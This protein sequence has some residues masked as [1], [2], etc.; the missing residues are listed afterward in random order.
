MAAQIV[1]GQLN[2]SPSFSQSGVLGAL[3]AFVTTQQLPSF[4]S[5]Q[6]VNGTGVAY[7]VDQLY[8]AQL[9]FT[10]STA[11]TFHFETATLTDPFGNTLAM[12]RIRELIVLNTSPT[13]GWDLSVAQAASN[14]IA[15]LPVVANAPPQARANGGMVR[16]SD[17]TTFGAAVGN[18]ITNTT[19]GLVLTPT[20]HA[21][22]A[23]ILCLGCS[24][25]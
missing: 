8:A 4:T 14:G 20:A 25:A 10:A 24:V 12:L 17:P 19:D 3:S 7:G 6:Y 13:I 9:T 15:W 5:I 18:F 2:F 21:V 1:T 22:T 16:I 23:V 11:Q